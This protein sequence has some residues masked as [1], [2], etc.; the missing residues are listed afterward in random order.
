VTSTQVPR[1]TL[2]RPA[3]ISLADA[4]KNTKPAPDEVDD[5]EELGAALDALDDGDE[6]DEE[7]EEEEEEEEDDDDD[8]ADDDDVPD[9]E[10]GMPSAPPAAEPAMPFG[11]PALPKRSPTTVHQLRQQQDVTN[12]MAV[13]DS[14]M[15]HMASL[16]FENEL[17]EVNLTRVEPQFDMAG[18]KCA[19]YLTTFKK[20]ITLEDVRQRFGGGTYKAVILR[21]M[22]NN[23]TRIVTSRTFDIAGEPV[24]SGAAGSAIAAAQA[25]VQ[26]SAENEVVKKVLDSRDKDVER[27][28]AKADQ[29]QAEMMKTMKS[30]EGITAQLLQTMLSKPDGMSAMFMQMQQQQMAQ[31]QQAQAEE[32]AARQRELEAQQKFAERMEEARRTQ[33]EKER[34]ESTGGAAQMS[35]MMMMMMQMQQQAS[36]ATAA[37]AAAQAAAQQAAAQQQMQMMMALMQNSSNEK[38]ELMKQQMLMQAE[39]SKGSKK[40]DDIIEQMLRM[41]QA[42]EIFNPSSG[43][44]EGAVS[45]FDKI[46][47]TVKEMAPGLLA[48][49]TASR[50]PVQQ[51]QQQPAPQ[52]QLPPARPQVTPGSVAVVDL[53]PGE[54]TPAQRLRLKK[55]A[56]KAA[57]SPEEPA[58]LVE[59]MDIPVPTSEAEMATIKNDIVDKFNPT[60]G[61]VFPVAEGIQDQVKL[62]VAN[63]EKAL[64]KGETPAVFFIDVVKKFPIT[65]VS[66]LK[67]APLATIYET[68]GDAAP[69]DWE[70]NSIKGQHFIR[71]LLA[72][73]KKGS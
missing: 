12:E 44:G 72:L 69:M 4:L 56:A 8:D 49:F 58:P 21:R 42:I 29:L 6:P 37:Q 64:R 9:M 32:R 3:P 65:T 70:L 26:S 7:E 53:D 73:A 17:H 67:V 46:T 28:Q 34:M 41:K 51:F 48:A 55:L 43:G 39:Q 13:L 22:P 11:I 63:I 31:Q 57:P 1:N 52:P 54:V 14:F 40:G 68:L 45:T 59:A 38:T 30:G 20:P 27:L 24:Q 36:Q 50:Q 23:Q 61:Y 71:D 35:Q 62:L 60:E 5:D 33:T 25:R 15:S 66:L 2:R 47:D 16:S 18:R 10:L 19:G